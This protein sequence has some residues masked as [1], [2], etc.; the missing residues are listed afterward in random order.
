MYSAAVLHVSN[1]LKWIFLFVWFQ[2]ASSAWVLSHWCSLHFVVQMLTLQQTPD[3]E[4]SFQ[5]DSVGGGTLM[6][7][8][9]CYIHWNCWLVLILWHLLC[10]FTLKCKWNSTPTHTAFSHFCWVKYCD[11]LSTEHWAFNQAIGKC[12]VSTYRDELKVD[13]TT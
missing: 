12:F 9:C 2:I 1:T 13:Y 5:P 10:V 8:V 6:G 4:R 7:A 3:A 11:H